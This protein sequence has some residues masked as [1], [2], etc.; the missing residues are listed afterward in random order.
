M[1]PININDVA[2]ILDHLF[3]KTHISPFRLIACALEAFATAT[4]LLSAQLVFPAIRI[5]SI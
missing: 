5:S 3:A 2:Q 4:N 1:L